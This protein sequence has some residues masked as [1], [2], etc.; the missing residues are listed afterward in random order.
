M[1]SRLD[2]G[3]RTPRLRGQSP[4]NENCPKGGGVRINIRKTLFR[5]GYLLDQIGRDGVHIMTTKIL[6][7]SRNARS[8][9]GRKVYTN[10]PY[11]RAHRRK[12]LFEV[13]RCTESS[14]SDGAHCRRGNI[15]STLFVFQ[16]T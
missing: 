4:L 15:I 5:E 2:T 13:L 1:P 10:N 16:I 12:L 11:M 3:G 6:L 8:T 14:R 9:D 7:H